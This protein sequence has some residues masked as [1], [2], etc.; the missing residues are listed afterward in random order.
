[1]SEGTS[2]DPDA[3]APKKKSGALKWVLIIL[4]G[5]CGLCCCGIVGAAIYGYNQIGMSFDPQVART[6]TQEIADIEVPEGM[7]PKFSMSMMGMMKMAV[8]VGGEDGS[9]GM[10]MLIEGKQGVSKEQL[11]QSIDEQMKKQGQQGNISI[12]ERKTKTYTVRGEETSFEIAK[13]KAEGRDIWQVSGD[14]ASKEGGRAV[15]L[16]MLPADKFDE[17][18]IDGVIESIK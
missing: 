16:M 17:E 6:R 10:F 9:G 12:E 7:E 5:L 2:F 15:I 18:D 4:G 8:W 13:G 14:F 1:M 3:P 11:R